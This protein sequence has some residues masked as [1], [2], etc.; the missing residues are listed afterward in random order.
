MQWKNRRRTLQKTDLSSGTLLD[1]LSASCRAS[2]GG[3]G[4]RHKHAYTRVEWQ[5]R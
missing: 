2:P 5:W 3:Y 4:S 1:A